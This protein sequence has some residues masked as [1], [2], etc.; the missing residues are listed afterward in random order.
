MSPVKIYKDIEAML[1]M[2][3]LGSGLRLLEFRGLHSLSLHT[4]TL[5]V[6]SICFIG[7]LLWVPRPEQR[8]VGGSRYKASRKSS[9]QK[10]PKS[11]V[12]H[13]TLYTDKLA[14]VFILV[15]ALALLGS[16]I[17]WALE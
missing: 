14:S 3:C 1:S 16:D 6:P 9:L 7:P 12:L 10:R 11:S 4:R 2:H 5:L 17:K 8:V 15:A 13:C